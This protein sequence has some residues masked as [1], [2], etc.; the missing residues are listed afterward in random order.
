M[1]RDEPVP[2]FRLPEGPG[3]PL[4]L[5]RLVERRHQLAHVERLR[6]VPKGRAVD[7]LHGAGH[8]GVTGDE[9]HLGLRRR[10]LDRLE[11][12]EP[13]DVWQL[14]VDDRGIDRTRRQ[15]LEPGAAAV[16]RPDG[17]APKL[18]DV[19]ERLARSRVVINDEDQ[20]AL[21]HETLRAARPLPRRAGRAR[22][23]PPSGH[24]EPRGRRGGTSAGS[25]GER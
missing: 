14:Q 11:E 8:G 22:R 9:N 7:R 17:M 20:A 3:E 25:R 19:P 6:Q 5:E 18:Q 1:L 21:R 4:L 16:S 2:L 12:V 10:R 15:G 23:P 13:G 24:P